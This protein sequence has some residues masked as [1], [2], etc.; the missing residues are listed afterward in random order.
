M[1]SEYIHRL[2]TDRERARDRQRERQRERG[3]RDVEA[4]GD[5]RER[6]RETHS[7]IQTHRGGR[8]RRGVEAVGVVSGGDGSEYI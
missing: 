5:A 7:Q 1:D 6:E 8:V 2:Y 3:R 4:V